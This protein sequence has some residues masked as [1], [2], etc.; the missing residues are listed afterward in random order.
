MPCDGGLTVISITS[1]PVAW[2]WLILIRNCLMSILIY[3]I[4]TPEGHSMKLNEADW[5][6]PGFSELDTAV[7]QTQDFLTKLCSTLYVRTNSPECVDLACGVR[8]ECICVRY[9]RTW[10]NHQRINLKTTNILY[11]FRKSH[12][13]ESSESVS[14]QN[15]E[16]S[17]PHSLIKTASLFARTF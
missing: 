6:E 9:V 1:K 16:F 8:V 17:L 11:I 4:Y 7:F 15:D 13:N 5:D 3:V 10:W 12:E 14:Y 2:L